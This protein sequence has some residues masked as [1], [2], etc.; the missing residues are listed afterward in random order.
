MGDDQTARRPRG[1]TKTPLKSASPFN[2]AGLF[3][4][5]GHGLLLKSGMRL[6]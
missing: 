2:P 4:Q 1:E 3:L 6:L 5:A